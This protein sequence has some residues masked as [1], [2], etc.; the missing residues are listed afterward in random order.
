MRVVYTY[1]VGDVIHPGHLGYMQSA[2]GLGD[3]LIVGVLTDKAVME[4]KSKPI[5]NFHERLFMLKNI[6][7]VDCV[8]AQ[9]EYSPIKNIMN[10]KPNIVVESTSHD[11]DHL[12]AV[13]KVVEEIGGRVIILPYY[14][15]HSSTN[16][17]EKIRNNGN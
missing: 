8:V 15:G 7:C 16:I 17:K 9:D 10:I 5:L 14:P 6:K 12:D 3:K 2:K 1:L 11:K 13:Q 4:K